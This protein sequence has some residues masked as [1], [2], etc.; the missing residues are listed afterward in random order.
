MSEVRIFTAAPAMAPLYARAV[1][2]SLP[3]RRREVPAAGQAGDLEVRRVGVTTDID[4]LAAYARLTGGGLDGRLPGLYP[5]LA[6]FAPQLALMTDARFG[7]AVLGLV[8]VGTTVTVHRLLSRA[9]AY[10]VVVRTG[11]T[12]P[13]RH[14]RLVD[15][16]TSVTIAGQTAWEETT[17]LLSRA[18]GGDPRAVDTS[19]LAALAAPA[20]QTRWAVPAHTGRA[21][22]RLS[23]DRNPIHLSRLTANAFGFPRAIAHGM[24]TAARVLAAVEPDVPAPYRYDVAFRSPLLLPAEVRFGTR[25]DPDAGL[26]LGVVSAD[27]VR[28]HLVARVQ[29]LG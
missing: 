19:P 26:L 16:E 20:G 9:D 3:G 28:Q 8:H 15:L 14:G 12:R 22:A 6:A 4:H 11:R 2:G 1:R 23:G 27:G 24:W 18:A 21:Y 10:D 13:H 17:T 7:F 5:H 25:T 29:P